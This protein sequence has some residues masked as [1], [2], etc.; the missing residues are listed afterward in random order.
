MTAA[1]AGLGSTKGAYMAEI[2]RG[3]LLSVRARRSH[4]SLGMTR[5]RALRRIILPQA[6]RIIVPP[7]ATS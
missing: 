6:M 7:P 4:G 1:I 5:A 2:M 3:G